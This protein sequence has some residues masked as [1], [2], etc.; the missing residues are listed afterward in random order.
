MN[1]AELKEAART[2]VSPKPKET[3]FVRWYPTGDPSRLNSPQLGVATRI[4]NRTIDVFVLT[5]NSRGKTFSGVRHVSDPKLSLSPEHRA[6]GAWD[7]TAEDVRRR[8]WE[9][10]IEHQLAGLRLNVGRK[11]ARESKEGVLVGQE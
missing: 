3:Q 10:D 11:N 9:T 7:F 4:E 5:G 1:E 8:E 6:E 2:F